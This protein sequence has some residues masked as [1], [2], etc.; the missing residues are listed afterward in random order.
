MQNISKWNKL[1]LLLFATSFLSLTNCATQPPDVPVFEP[2]T[3]RIAHDPVTDHMILLPSPLCMKNIQEFECGH[4]VFIISGNE[5][6]VGEDPKHWYKGKSWSQL[7]AQSIYLPAVESAA[8]LWTYIINA[9]AK[10]QCNDQ[11]DRYRVQLD[12]LKGV[13]PALGIP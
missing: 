10:A 6:W 2:Y 13:G 5:V 7:K 12:Q 1:A 3:Q 4:G 8:P 9:C 11:V